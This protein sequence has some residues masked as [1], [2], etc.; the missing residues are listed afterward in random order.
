V[1]LTGKTCV[2]TGASSGIG[3]ALAH[4]FAESGARVWGIA[5]SSD[6][7]QSLADDAESGSGAIVPLAAD[8]ERDEDLERAGRQILSEGGP[9]DVF[10][11]SAGAITR[12][13][14]ESAHVEDLDRQYAVNLRSAFVLTQALLPALKRSRGHVVFV[15]S[16]AGVASQAPDAALYAATKHGLRAFADSLRQEVNPDGVR[17]LSLYLGRTDTPMQMAVHKHEGR[18]YRPELLL[19]PQDVVDV[20]LSVLSLASTAEVTDVNLRPMAK[21]PER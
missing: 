16:S 7:L 11:H 2:V 13:R 14:V 1:T 3:R 8:L 12:G 18:P 9:V 15:N 21:L 19:Q 5:R 6:R 4:A 20:V 10:V 17:V